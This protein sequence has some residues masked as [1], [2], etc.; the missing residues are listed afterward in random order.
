MVQKNIEIRVQLKYLIK[1]WRTLEMPLVNCETNLILT[2]SARCFIIDGPI[3]GQEPT[4]TITDKKLYVPVIT[5][6][7]QN[8]CNN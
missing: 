2:W 6:P 3:G 4:F 7:T 8:Y 5:L 1:F